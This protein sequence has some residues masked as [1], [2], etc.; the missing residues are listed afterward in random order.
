MSGYEP[1]VE[2]TRGG[3]HLGDPV[4]SIHF[5]AFA[6]V[7]ARG[8]LLAAHGDPTTVTYMRSSAKPFQAL[9]FI[10][11]GG[12]AAYQLTPREIALICASHSGTDDHVATVQGI[13]T[14]AGIQETD[15][16]CGTHAI[17]HKPTAEAMRA[18]GEKITTNR[19]NCSGKHT[20]MVAHCRLHNLPY[21]DYINPAHP[22]Q[23]EI[24]QAFSAM[25]NLPASQV[26]VGIDGCSAPNFAVPLQNAALGFARLLDPAE[27]SSERSAACHTI[28]DAM[29]SHPDMVG[30]PDSFDTHLMQTTGGRFLC[31]SGAEGYL[32]LG[33][34]PGILANTAP[35]IG[36]VLKISDGDARGT[37][38]PSVILEI[39]TQMGL[40][41]PEEI[42]ALQEYGPRLELRNF[43]KLLVGAMRPNFHLAL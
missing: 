42:T 32:A 20:G 6:I 8:R 21:H 22:V 43:R 14:K 25:C 11:H 40:L 12:P 2:L 37:V 35:G 41:T 30:G 17:S 5:G 19:H 15:L 13:Q 16:L 38:R 24:L 34:R 31:K 9:P 39:L 29:T 3:L 26:N 36:I 10:E 4:E 28:T 27:L 7:D 1:L 18:R 23:Q 33:I